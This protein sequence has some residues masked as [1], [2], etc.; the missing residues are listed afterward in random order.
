V[1][2]TKNKVSFDLFGIFFDLIGVLFDLFGL[3]L[4]RWDLF[5]LVDL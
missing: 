2:P 3:I 1:S 4:I 5:E